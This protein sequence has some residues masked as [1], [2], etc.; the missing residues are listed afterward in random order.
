M[1][2]EE[3][4]LDEESVDSL[5]T[6]LHDLAGRGRV[7]S[8]RAVV[9]ELVR[10]R[11]QAPNIEMY[12]A[13][14]ASNTNPDAGAAWRVHRLLKELQDEGL[15]PDQATCHN[16]LKV[17]AIHPDS[18]LSA[19][20]QRHM[21]DKWLPTT[22]DGHCD[23]T[24]GLLRQ[25]CFEMAL[26]NLDAMGREGTK[27]QPWLLDM[28]AYMLCEAGEMDMVY[29]MVRSRWENAEIGMSPILWSWILDHAST[30]RHHPLTEFV[31]RTQVELG[32]LQASS[33]MCYGTL[34]TA[35]RAGD[36]TLATDVLRYLAKRG[37]KNTPLHYQL[38]IDAYMN[39]ETPDVEK[40]LSVLGVMSMEKLQATVWH[41][42]SLFVYLSKS[43]E[44]VQEAFAT[45][46]QLHADG[47]AIPIAA[48]NLILE[49]YVQQRNLVEAEKVYKQM[50]T[51][52]S[53]SAKTFA[54]TETFNILLKA[55]RDDESAGPQQ[56]GFFI[57]E[58]LAL[59]VQP[60]ALT[61]DRLILAFTYAASRRENAVAETDRQYALQCIDLACRYFNEIQSLDWRPRWQTLTALMLCL[62][63]NG[64]GRWM[65]LMQF[66][67]DNSVK[68]DDWDTTGPKAKQRVE[69]AW[70]SFKQ[71]F[72]M[73]DL[74]KHRQEQRQEIPVQGETQEGELQGM[75]EPTAA[76][77]SVQ[78]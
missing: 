65:D 13:L 72:L 23:I 3:A 33:G 51:F 77:A 70:V 71:N 44:L 7:D 1:K 20:I 14:I 63:R 62:A 76:I 32:F 17:L 21:R 50:H 69:S 12:N 9:Q 53:N 78:V 43:P 8:C 6:R 64:D 37:E 66:A 48:I 15:E 41:T 28:F 11:G 47:R 40:A 19:D 67:D 35:S 29:R 68:G 46:Q 39:G 25:G 52:N 26:D 42:R 56:A 49:C 27:P 30:A 22:A 5:Y 24:V 54:N 10:E 36:P 2:Y 34:S 61:Y 73:G 18:L 74:K 4:P 55:C 45:L 59:R 38:L 31:W 75:A 16:V 57:S 60:D 58:M